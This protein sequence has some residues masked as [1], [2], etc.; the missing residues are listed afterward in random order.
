MHHF[1]HMGNSGKIDN[2]QQ[3]HA[4]QIT[5]YD[6]H[7]LK[8]LACCP[9]VIATPTVIAHRLERTYQSF[10]AMHYTIKEV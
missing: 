1:K 5:Y 4:N 7:N 3:H 9:T 10:L 6:L 8:R 2:P